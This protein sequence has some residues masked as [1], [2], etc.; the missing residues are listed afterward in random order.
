MAT[1]IDGALPEGA[2]DLGHDTFYTKVFSNGGA[3]WVGIHEWHKCGN[4]DDYSA[5]F[6]GFVDRGEDTDRRFKTTWNVESEE[7]LTL[8]PS[9]QCG[10]C[11]H[12]GW[13]RNGRWEVA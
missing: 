2:I 12:H 8:T 1:Y 3:R 11:K 9:L 10:T 13:I 7:P 5:G 6:V 4:D